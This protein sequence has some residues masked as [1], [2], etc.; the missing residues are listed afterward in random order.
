MAVIRG[1]TAD[2]RYSL[3]ITA[4]NAFGEGPASDVIVVKTTTGGKCLIGCTVV[5][6]IFYNMES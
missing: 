1:L 6:K 3:S 5:K 2:V 4:I